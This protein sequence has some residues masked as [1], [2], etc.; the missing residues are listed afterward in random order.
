M[1]EICQKRKEKKVDRRNEVLTFIID[2]TSIRGDDSIESNSFE[3]SAFCDCKSADFCL[4]LPGSSLMRSLFKQ[5]EQWK[6]QYWM[7]KAI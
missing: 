7:L 3:S 4:R 6:K 1:N 2:M 5:G